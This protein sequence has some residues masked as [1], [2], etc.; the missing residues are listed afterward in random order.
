MPDKKS[1][2]E[3]SEIIEQEGLGYAVQHYL[4]AAAC[5]DPEMK[6]LWAQAKEALD[7]IDTLASAAKEE[8]YNG[9]ERS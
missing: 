4:N 9:A 5:A 1:N 6:K 2:F 7:K 8:E 3:I